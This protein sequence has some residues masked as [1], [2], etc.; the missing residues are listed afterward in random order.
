MNFKRKKIESE[1]FNYFYC[2]KFYKSDFDLNI[3]RRRQK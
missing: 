1:N 3:I 2:Y